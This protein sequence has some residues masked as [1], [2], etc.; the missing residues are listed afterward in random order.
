M[1]PLPSPTSKPA[2]EGQHSFRSQIKEHHIT[3]YSEEQSLLSKSSQLMLSSLIGAAVKWFRCR[4]NTETSWGLTLPKESPQNPI[5][6]SP[7][8]QRHCEQVLGQQGTPSRDSPGE[9]SSSFGSL[10]QNQ[11]GKA[12]PKLTATHSATEKGLL[13]VTAFLCRSKSISRS[14]LAQLCSPGEAQHSHFRLPR[15]HLLSLLSIC[16]YYLHMKTAEQSIHQ[17][18]T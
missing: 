15:P 7:T 4:C 18:L 3:K 11:T 10:D 9:H 1:V 8:L 17:L 13:I 16:L 5:K 6:P 2:A 12:A 14:L